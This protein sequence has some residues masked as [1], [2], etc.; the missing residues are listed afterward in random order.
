MIGF[1]GQY[2][3]TIDDK[4][5]VRVPAKYKNQLGE[6]FVIA[7]GENACLTIYPLETWE[8]FKQQI[9][10]LSDLDEKSLEFKR[11]LYSNATFGEFDS[12]GRVLIP[13]R[14]RKYANLT[15]AV[16]ASGVDDHFE[17]WN[18]E[19]WSQGEYESLD[20]RRELQREISNAISGGQN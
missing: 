1:L 6:D 16:V 18:A 5:R 2:D 15:K 13:L 10:Q 12:A 7:C 9:S 17:L 20:K 3:I 4:G 14:F 19:T 11:R 8:K